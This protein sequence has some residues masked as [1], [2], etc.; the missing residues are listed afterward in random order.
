LAKAKKKAPKNG[1]KNK[2]TP[3]NRKF[4]ENYI[5]CGNATQAYIDA[6]YSENG[7]GISA[8]KLLKNPKIHEAIEERRKEIAA[9]NNITADRVINEIAKIAFANSED[10]FE[11]G[12]VSVEL[13]DGLE[14]EKGIAILK[15]PEQLT[16]DHKA[17]IHSIEETQHG[18]KLKLYDKQKALD[19]LKQYLGVNNEAEIKKALTIKKGDTGKDGSDTS[20]E[21]RIKEKMKAHGFDD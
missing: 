19:S 20:I 13:A 12:K 3:R 15:T 2:I 7:A 6:G 21:Q 11:W 18:I 5:N 4:I 9:N 14:I 16:R 17:S 1:R 10:F 8:F